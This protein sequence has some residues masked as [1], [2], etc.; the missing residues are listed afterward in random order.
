MNIVIFLL[1]SIVSVA[2]IFFALRFLQARATSSF[3]ENSRPLELSIEREDKKLK[4]LISFKDAYASKAQLN[5]L[6]QQAEEA[7]VNLEQEKS[8]LAEI[9]SKLDKA[10]QGVEEREAGQQ[11]IR[12]G[13]EADEETLTEVFGQ[14]EELSKASI[15]LEQKLGKA[16]K[17]IDVLMEADEYPIE[18]KSVLEEFTMAMTE[19]GS[20]LRDVITEHQAMHDRLKALKQQ[21]DDLED[22]YTKLVEQQLG[23]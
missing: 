6:L 19:T 5:H 14:F 8:L 12:A 20:K 21:H 1:V 13:D 18:K 15:A 2:C 7:K 9:E 23:E 4:R 22:E 3:K 17:E 10:Q 11:E 16:L